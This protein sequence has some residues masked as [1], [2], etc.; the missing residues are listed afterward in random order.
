METTILTTINPITEAFQKLAKS[1]GDRKSLDYLIE[2]YDQETLKRELV[3]FSKNYLISTVQTEIESMNKYKRKLSTFEDLIKY[4]LKNICSKDNLRPAMCKVYND[5]KN[6]NLVATDAHILAW[7][8]LQYL[9]IS[10]YLDNVCKEDLQDYYK[11][12]SDSENSFKLD[13]YGDIVNEDMDNRYPDYKAVFPEANLLD[14][15]YFS[16]NPYLFNGLKTIS[17]I[18]KKLKINILMVKLSCL[19][20]NTYLNISL[21]V[22]YIDLHQKLYGN[23]T[24]LALTR[25]GYEEGKALYNVDISGKYK[26]LL[27]PCIKSD[28]ENILDLDL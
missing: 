9:P 6:G 3:Y 17:K 19:E 7:L 25:N 28:E 4:L 18:A 8:P 15:P 26:L 1:L 20:Y 2:N 21:L 12:Y 13:K 23:Y 5:Q 22:R 24:F 11:I 14:Y 10:D 27:M 16:I